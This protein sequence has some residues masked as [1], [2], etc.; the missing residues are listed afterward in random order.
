MHGGEACATNSMS[1]AERADLGRRDRCPE[2]RG[3]A[4]MAHQW[5]WVNRLVVWRWQGAAVAEQ[6]WPDRD[7]FACRRWR[8]GCGDGRRVGRRG[9]GD[10]G[11][12]RWRQWVAGRGVD[13]VGEAGGVVQ[14]RHAQRRETE[15]V[16]QGLADRY[17]G[18]PAGVDA[19]LD[20]A[21]EH[22]QRNAR[23]VGK[24]DAVW[25]ELEV[26][27]DHV[28][29]PPAP[30]VP[31]QQEDCTLPQ[32]GRGDRVHRLPHLVL[33][34]AYVGD[35]VLVKGWAVPDHGECR[36]CARLGVGD[37]LVGADDIR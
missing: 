37:D 23:P 30:V 27:S 33:A 14:A 24:L 10:R 18:V 29:I 13:Q 26:G 8:Q 15:Q 3:R 19:G 32:P 7:G 1:Y 36:Q 4:L 6:H 25:G 22:E 11:A 28:I 12:V 21:A 20:R 17:V 16:E 5:L 31:G 9:L 34:E 2:R 35:R